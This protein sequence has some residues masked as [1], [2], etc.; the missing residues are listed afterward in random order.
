MARKTLT[1]LLLLS[2]GCFHASIES[3]MKPGNG[4]DREGVGCSWVFGL[5]PP[6]PIEAQSKCTAG[7]SKVETEHSFLNA[8]VRL[9]HHPNLHP[10]APHPDL[11]R[12]PDRRRPAAG[13]AAPSWPARPDGRSLE[14]QQPHAL[15]GRGGVQPGV[16]ASPS[17]RSRLGHGEREHRARARA[18]GR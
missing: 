3:G 11:R 16:S 8:L 10:D 14:D 9:L 6:E 13:D 2:A 15:G 17:G 7:V 18:S 1:A 4:R 12:E 5:V